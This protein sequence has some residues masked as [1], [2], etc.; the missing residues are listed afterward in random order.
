MGLVGNYVSLYCSRLFAQI[1]VMNAYAFCFC[2]TWIMRVI[3]GF[4]RLFSCAL[5]QLSYVFCSTWQVSDTCSFTQ[6]NKTWSYLF[7]M[8]LDYFFLFHYGIIFSNMIF[9]YCMYGIFPKLMWSLQHKA[10]VRILLYPINVW[11]NP[12]HWEKQTRRTQIDRHIISRYVTEKTY[13]S[14]MTFV[15]GI[16]ARQRHQLLLTWSR[17]SVILVWIAGLRIICEPYLHLFTSGSIKH[18]YV[19]KAR[20]KTVF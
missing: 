5:Q 4:R 10:N 18:T 14:D 19:R 17:Q 3:F 15:C 8:K 12:S 6:R 16:K 13:G 11:E 20:S 7:L 2:P 9:S 1:A